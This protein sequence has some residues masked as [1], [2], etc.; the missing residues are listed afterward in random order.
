MNDMRY[1]C[2]LLR[3][4]LG[5]AAVAI[6]TMAVGIGAT[7]TLFSVAYGVLLKPLPWAGGDRLVRLTES[8]KGQQARLPGTISNGAYLAW[9]NHASTVEAIGGYGVGGDA[10]TAVA[11][12]GEPARLQVVRLT[13]SMFDVLRARPLHGRAF[14]ADDERHDSGTSPATSVAIISYGLW[15]EWFGGGDAIG[16]VMRV[17]EQPVTIVGIM[18]REFAFPDQETRAWLPMPVGGVLSA[19]GVRRIQIFGAMAR[20]KPGVTPQQAAA[21]ATAR[22]RTAPDPGFAAVAMFGNDAPSDVTVTPAIDAMTAEVRPAIMLLLAAVGVL[23]ATAT[24]NVGGLQL[25]RATTRRRELAV[26]A[27]LGASHGHLVRQLVAE[28]A[29]IGAAGAVAG[30]TIAA[31]TQRLLPALL[32]ADF[33][34]VTDIAVNL[35]VM[36][37]AAVLAIVASVACGLMPATETGR[38]DLTHALAE[39]SRASVAGPGRSR[40]GR[41]RA[42]VTTTQVALACLLLVGAALLTRSF[43][44][45][46]H[47]DRG[48]DPANMLTA[49]LD[50]PQQTSDG[51]RHV[52][53]SDAV[54][55]RM[56]A[57][58]GVATAAAADALPFL[59]LGSAGGTEMPSLV[60][61]AVKQ[62]V[63]ANLRIVGPEYFTALRLR[64]LQGRLLSDAEG[65]STRPVVVVSRSFARQYL[66]PEPLGTRVPLRSGRIRARADAEVVGVVDDVRQTSVT[67]PAAADLYIAYRQFPDWWTRGSIMFVVRTTDDPLAHVQALRTA[68]REQDP[69]VALDSIMT[70]EERVANSLAKPRLYAVLLVSF[71]VAALAIAAVG[72]FGLLSYVVAQRSREIGIRTALGAQTSHILALV[73]RQATAISISGVAAGLCAAYVL[74][75]YLSSFIY[76]VDRADVGSYIT[77][78]FAVGLVATTASIV[79]AWRAARIDPLVALRTE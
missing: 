68:V 78:A 60:N 57:Q 26:R 58:P 8:R 63:R 62:Q 13:A 32:P 12:G 36:L 27:A 42:A 28:S 35:P 24:A 66:G 15:Q 21:E 14:T 70:M 65:P 38:L 49:Q 20:L 67:E 72:L 55:A 45:L 11:N 18:P 3:R 40:G 77:V 76:G 59:S 6:L 22:A 25:A 16:R 39:D 5:Y 50:L 43:V 73:L 52:A 71:A 61:P 9:R 75:R 79:P 23:L 44:A 7:T 31:L 56:R 29:M 33:P 37:C 51:R 46:L 69:T 53:L 2:R 30:V 47:V 48:Y 74:T 17:D 41:L 34:R 4:D 10:M 64:L 1:A 19:S 54:I